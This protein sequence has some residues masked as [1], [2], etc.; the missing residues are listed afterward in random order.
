MEAYEKNNIALRCFLEE[1]ATLRMEAARKRCAERGVVTI[2]ENLVRA[3]GIDSID[4]LNAAIAG[5]P[6]WRQLKIGLT[7]PPGIRLKFP[8]LGQRIYLLSVSPTVRMETH[9]KPEVRD[10]SVSP[11]IGAYAFGR[12][13]SCDRPFRVDG[14]REAQRASRG[15]RP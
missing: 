12:V 1:I 8:T 7:R 5:S 3:E 13:G 10:V 14:S 11:G 6:Q 2:F 15:S 9:G 4:R